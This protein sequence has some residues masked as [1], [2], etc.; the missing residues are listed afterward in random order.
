MKNL[1]PYILV[2]ILSAGTTFGLIQYTKDNP[3][4]TQQFTQSATEEGAHFATY[5]YASSGTTMPDF[6][7]AAET[8]VNAVVSIKNFGA[9]RQQQQG[10]NP[11]DF[12][13]DPFFDQ[14]FNQPRNQRQ[15]RNE[16]RPSGAGSGVIISE[17]GYIVTN[18]HVIDGAS[19]LEV[20]LNN[21]QS[22]TARVVGTDP[23]TDIALIKIDES[24]LPFLTF[25]NSDNLRVGEWV[26]AV[27]NP[28]S[29]NS[30]VTAG[31]V[32]ATG[33]RIGILNQSGQHPIESFI[34]TDAAINPGN[35][36]GALVNT[37]GHLVGINTAI[38]SQTGSYAG[39]GFAIPAN[40]ARKIVEDIRSYG[41]VQRG[42]IGISGL[43]LSNA[44]QVR[45]Y[46]Q[47]RQTEVKTGQG[48]MVIGLSEGGGAEEAGLREGDIIR[49]IDGTAINAFSTLSYVVGNK[50]PGDRVSVQVLRDG[51]ER[52]FPVVLKDLRGHETIRTLDDLTVIEKLG[53][54][55]ENLSER[56][57]VQYGIDKG[58]MAINVDGRGKLAGIGINNGY[59]I[60]KINN[61]EV[62]SEKDIENIL[63]SY[64]GNVTVQYVDRYGRIYQQGFTL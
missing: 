25:F 27:G 34:Q 4:F 53:A 13:N 54:D 64:S 28:F 43:D 23:N 36:G 55:F 7:R 59:I 20:T 56:Q 50:N 31:I 10:A 62:D 35:S 9:T 26:L 45:R 21:Q 33:R 6:T 38:Y 17:D 37:N 57:K 29:L 22:Y 41:M 18:N 58:V 12:F 49:N 30:T 61:K 40:M 14:F 16:N 2:G 24:N 51:K 39:Y 48:V 32:S 46:N 44:E 15:Q 1:F 47:D 11:M 42:Y 19:R 52:T 8:S 3:N 60:L 5:D 63:K